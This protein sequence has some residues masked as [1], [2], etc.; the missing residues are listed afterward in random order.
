[1]ARKKTKEVITVPIPKTEI[2]NEANSQIGALNSLVASAGWAM[3]VRILNENIAYLERA[4]L[5]KKDPASGIELT[6]EEVEKLRYKRGLNMELKDT[7]QKYGRTLLEMGEVPENFD[8]Y[9]SKE[10]IKKMESSL[11]SK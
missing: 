3:I 7:P 1:M 10:D 9:W 11:K 4:I 8:P 6:D 2:S 5:E